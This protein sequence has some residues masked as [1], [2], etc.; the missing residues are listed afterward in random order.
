M[1]KALSHNPQ[2]AQYLSLNEEHNSTHKI[3]SY[4]AQQKL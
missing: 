3:Q 4:K 2:Q 1:C